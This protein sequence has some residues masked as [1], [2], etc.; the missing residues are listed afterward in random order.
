MRKIAEILLLNAD[1]VRNIL[2]G[3]S[4][5]CVS[6]ENSIDDLVAVVFKDWRCKLEDQ[7]VTSKSKT[8]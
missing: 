2:E 5:G 8:T 3:Y 4:Y 6:L 7:C 1:A